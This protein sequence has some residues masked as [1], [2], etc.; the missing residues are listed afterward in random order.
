[1]AQLKPV[2]FGIDGNWYWHRV[3]NILQQRID[4]VQNVGVSMGY[5]LLSKICVDALAVKANQLAVFF[6]GGSIFR[7]ELYDKYK[8]SRG[9]NGVV[10]EVLGEVMVFLDR[11]GIAVMQDKRLE[12]DD[13]LCSLGHRYAP[14]HRVVIGTKDKDSFQYLQPSVR[15]YDSTFKIK[16]VP[17]PRYFTH[18]DVEEK[19]GLPPSLM[20]QYQALIGD[21]IDDIPKIITPAVARK[22]LLKYGSIKNWCA[23]D[24]EIKSTLE[25]HRGT[26]AIN[27]KLVTLLPDCL[28]PDFEP[29]AIR[30]WD[31][32]SLPKNYFNLVDFM[33][34]KG[35]GLFR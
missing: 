15:L 16:G 33:H 27:R 28:P 19:L 3:W 9:D 20:I 18:L 14:T 30:K 34:P 24:P 21:G 13:F 31:N 35:K 5:S 23:N 25:D 6:D 10:Y 7:Y 2:L 29:Q 12:A 8:E 22:G 17:S 1:M 32:Q 26:L 4:S 11:C